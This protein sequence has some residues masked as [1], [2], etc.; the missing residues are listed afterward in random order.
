MTDIEDI[1]NVSVS[2][3]NMYISQEL[4]EPLKNLLNY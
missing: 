1:A 2:K 4:F 3:S